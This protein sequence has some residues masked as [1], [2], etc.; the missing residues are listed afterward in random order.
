MHDISLLVSLNVLCTLISPMLHT[1]MLVE[2]ASWRIE[3]MDKTRG[4]PVVLAC[5]KQLHFIR[6]RMR[7]DADDTVHVTAVRAL[8][9]AAMNVEQ[10]HGVGAN[11]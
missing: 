5:S 2:N 10:M 8:E 7:D 6:I 11:N 3:L 1:M 9:R 4:A